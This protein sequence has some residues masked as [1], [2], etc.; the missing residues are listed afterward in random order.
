MIAFYRQFIPQCAN[1]SVPLN[2]LLR[3][4]KKWCWA[5]EQQTA[6]QTLLTALAE[7]ASLQLPDLNKP[8][9]VQT[10]ASEFGLGAVLLQEWDQVLRPVA[11]AS[12]TLTPAERNY[13]VTEKECLAI[14]FALKKFDM[15]LDG[16]CFTIQTDHQALSWLQRLQNPAGRLA[17]WALALQRYDYS[18]DYKK[19]TTNTV[20]DALSRA[21]FFTDTQVENEES[22]VVAAVQAPTNDRWGSLVSQQD[23]V[24][25]Q[26]SDGLCRKVIDKLSTTDSPEASRNDEVDS[27]LLGNQGILLRYIPQ[28]DDDS[29][30]TPFR[31]VVPR[32][33]HLPNRTDKSPATFAADLRKR[34]T[35]S[36]REAREHLDISRLDQTSQYDKRRRDVQFSMGDLVL[37]RTHPLSDASKGFTVSLAHRWDGPYTVKMSRNSSR[38]YPYHRRQPERSAPPQ[39]S[40]RRPFPPP[41]RP[42]RPTEE[43]ATWTVLSPSGH[44]VMTASG[45]HIPEVSKI[46]VLGL[47]LNKRGRNDETINK[48]STKA[49]DA[50]RLIH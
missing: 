48:H 16:A 49:M 5:S 21:P 47:L 44:P 50:I 32:K 13:S 26:R 38:A 28:A 9:V 1:I 15:F 18:I 17:R 29:T 34:L 10:D 7:N 37:K 2:E 20:A 12:H 46:R 39:G 41:Y 11:F 24:A 35:E 33:L 42:A 27:Y 6:F 30:Q 45:Q 8:F 14:V 3:K 36:V 19:G 31:V 40:L 25:A 23:L 4:G 22:M 43:V